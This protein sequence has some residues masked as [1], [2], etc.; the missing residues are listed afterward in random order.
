M[1]TGSAGL[2]EPM[3]TSMAGSESAFDPGKDLAAAITQL[4]LNVSKARQDQLLQYL[5]MLH[6]WN[7]AYNLSGLHGLREMLTLHLVDSL[8]LLPYIKADRVADVGTGPG[9]PGMI[10]AICMPETEF[11][12]IDSNSKKTRFIF[13]TA[14]SLGLHNVHAVHARVEGYAIT[15][16]VAIVTSRAF[17]S[18]R[19]FIES[20]QHLLSARGSMLAMKGQYPQPEIADL[21]AGFTLVASH[22]L[23]VPGT[24]V[25]RHLLEIRRTGM[26]GAQTT[27][28]DNG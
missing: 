28:T 6:K 13:Q 26:A 19:N 22:R 9:L 11:F 12:L 7:K 27:T 14:A 5:A 4:Q 2:P 8:T 24:D 17:A 21:P 16:Q 3:G 20:S 23:Q 1:L 15:P 25:N 18:L 10:L